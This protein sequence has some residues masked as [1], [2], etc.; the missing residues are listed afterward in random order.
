MTEL[1]SLDGLI[2]RAT[3]DICC[4]TINDENSREAR[5]CALLHLFQIKRL[6]V[7]SQGEI[8]GNGNR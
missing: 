4:I 6:I 2:D 3:S 1:I 8:N 5:Q 7:H